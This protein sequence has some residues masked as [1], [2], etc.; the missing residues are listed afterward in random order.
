M[1]CCFITNKTLTETWQ[2][3]L[4]LIGDSKVVVFGFNGLGLVSYKKELSGES[5]YF[6]DLA[7][8][9]RQ[10]NYVVI[11]GCD[12]EI[13]GEYRHSAVIGDKGRILGV[14]D[15]VH[16]VDD[17]EFLPGGNFRVYDTSAGKIGLI[18]ADD[19]FFP[20]SARVL[21]SCDADIII[22]I[23]KKIENS[24]P[25]IML[26]SGAFANGIVMALVSKNYYMVSN[27]KGE[28]ISAG[29][30]EINKVNI[31][32]EKDYHL[33]GSRRRG[34]YKEFPSGY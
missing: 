13:D 12:T 25:Q 9:S 24:L 33:I 3:S 27:V 29:S 19:L 1:D 11:C 4:D 20:E 34:F 8:F 6:Q 17:S 22:C 23:Y 7:R 26:R 15:A 14:S 10:N 32:I 30:D 28:I 16:S 5:E 2:N 31:K 18:V 21:S